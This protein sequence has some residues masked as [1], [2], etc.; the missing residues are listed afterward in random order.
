MSDLRWDLFASFVAGVA[1]MALAAYAAYR[2]VV[3][4]EDG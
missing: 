2:G 4:R 3:E 1:L